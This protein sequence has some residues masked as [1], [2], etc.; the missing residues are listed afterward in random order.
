MTTAF[1]L[2]S[3]I[4]D[5]SA[6]ADEVPGAPVTMDGAR[7]ELNG[8]P[9]HRDD[10]AMNGAQLLKFR[11]DSS[12][13]M[14]GPPAR[15]GE[16]GTGEPSRSSAWHSPVPKCEGPGAPSVDRRTGGLGPPAPWA[17]ARD[18]GHPVFIEGL[19]DWGHLRPGHRNMAVTIGPRKSLPLDDLP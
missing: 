9:A 1:L 3:S 14:G 18:W 5:P 10:A 6:A 13:L 17:N 19:A 7:G 11:G 8:R 12:G 15:G 2:S 4:P 16:Q